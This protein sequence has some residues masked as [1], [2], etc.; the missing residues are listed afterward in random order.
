MDVKAIRSNWSP[1]T[2]VQLRES[3]YASPGNPPR[4]RGSSVASSARDWLITNVNK[5]AD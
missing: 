1:V 2:R 4:S 3:S 5:L